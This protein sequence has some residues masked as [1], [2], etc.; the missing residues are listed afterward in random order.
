MSLKE[1]RGHGLQI[2]SAVTG[3]IT[4]ST[5]GGPI[6]KYENLRIDYDYSGRTLQWVDDKWVVLLRE[7]TPRRLKPSTFE[8]GSKYRVYR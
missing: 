7:P 4:N 6:K 8:S 3:D 2:I 1:G 5:L